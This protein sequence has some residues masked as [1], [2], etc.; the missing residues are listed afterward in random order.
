[1]SNMPLTVR[2]SIEVLG[3]CALGAIIILGQSVI[4]PLL[5]AFFISI[6]LLPPFRW[7]MRHKVP[8][9]LS[10]VFCIIGFIMLI[11]AVAFFLSWQIGGF[12]SDI[13]T[14]KKNLSIHWDNL[15]K[16]ISSKTHY[17]VEQQLGIIKQ[18]SS[19]LGSNI[20]GQIQGAL[21]SL[22]G[23]FIFLGLLPIYI[24]LIMFF[25]ILLLRFV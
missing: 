17:S 16:W 9:S 12:V 11:A 1:M 10:I 22:S 4:M 8:E 2:R 23:I 24:F 3:L 7:L 15:S 13:D 18:Q 25:R 21:A 19:K 6:V 14:I 20:T 5:M